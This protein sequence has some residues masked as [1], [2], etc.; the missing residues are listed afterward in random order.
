MSTRSPLSGIMFV[1]LLLA[2]IDLLAN[3]SVTGMVLSGLATPHIN[4]PPKNLA[5]KST[6]TAPTALFAQVTWGNNLPHDIDMSVACGSLKGDYQ[7]AT[8]NYKQL[9]SQ[10]L[11]LKQDDQG[12][13]SV[14]NL[15]KVE[16]NTDISKIPPLTRCWFDT[17]L[18]NTHG[19]AMPVT[20]ELLVIQYKDNAHERLVARVSFSLS[21]PDQEL[22]LLEA[23]WNERSELIEDIMETYPK[24]TLKPIMTARA[25]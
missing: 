13:P 24:T 22:T 17:H 5:D 3:V 4:P 12:L 20:G 6:D 11:V 14:I 25:E 9:R 8:V 23:T 15:E 10:W 7:L 18:Y 21:E 19:G 16:S 2:F 1:S